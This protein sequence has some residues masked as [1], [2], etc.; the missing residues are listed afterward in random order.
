MEEGQTLD[1]RLELWVD[2]RIEISLVYFGPGSTQVGIQTVWGFYHYL[3]A[4]VQ[5]A[6]RETI[7]RFRCQPQPEVLVRLL[8]LL[9]LQQPIQ[10]W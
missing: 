10:R 8:D 9:S 4:L 1:Q 5:H 2:A 3:V 7:S 6:Q